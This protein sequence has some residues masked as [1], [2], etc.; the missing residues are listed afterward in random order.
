DVPTQ[1]LAEVCAPAAAVSPGAVGPECFRFGTKRIKLD[2]LGGLAR[3][4]PDMPGRC[5]H[6]LPA[7]RRQ[8]VRLMSMAEPGDP[9]TN[10]IMSASLVLASILLLS[11]AGKLDLLW[12]VLPLSLLLTIGG[13]QAAGKSSDA[14]KKKGL[15]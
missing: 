3:V 2:P 14:G 5:P 6:W 13:K 7:R 10:Q 1:A 9:M 4:H 15:A 11:A 12:I 8:D